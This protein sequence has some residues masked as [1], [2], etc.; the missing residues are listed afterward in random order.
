MDQKYTQT[1]LEILTTAR[2]LKEIDD[3]FYSKIFYY[4]EEFDSRGE[5]MNP[6]YRSIG[7]INLDPYI[8][9]NQV[10]DWILFCT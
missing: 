8:E 6:T 5:I 9:V 7:V 4:K 3:K 10:R 2:K 1:Q